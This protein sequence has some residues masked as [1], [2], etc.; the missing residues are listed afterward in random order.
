MLFTL[1]NSPDI[2]DW[3]QVWKPLD[4]PRFGLNIAFTQKLNVHVEKKP[5][6]QQASSRLMKCHGV[7][8]DI[9][10]E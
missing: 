6:S 9:D 4:R 7:V 10:C 1:D 8:P 2:F 5:R 3:V